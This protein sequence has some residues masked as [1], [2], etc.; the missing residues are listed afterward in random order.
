MKIE[1]YLDTVFENKE[2]ILQGRK[3]VNM[4]CT[5]TAILLLIANIFFVYQLLFG[6]YFIAL[7]LLM[8][9]VTFDVLLMGLILKREIYS[10]AITLK[11]D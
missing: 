5:I 7:L 6:S 10:L 9:S 2:R 4:G 3:H 11:E 1:S 8:V